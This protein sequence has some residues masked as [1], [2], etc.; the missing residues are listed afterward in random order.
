MEWLA[1][2]NAESGENGDD[3][4]AKDDRDILELLKEQPVSSSGGYGR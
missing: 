1:A 2:Q 4:M 3:T